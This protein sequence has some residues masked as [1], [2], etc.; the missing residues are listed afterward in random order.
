M[1]SSWKREVCRNRKGDREYNAITVSQYGNCTGKI[2]S[3]K[4]DY[5][6]DRQS[7]CVMWDVRD[8]TKSNSIRLHYAEELEVVE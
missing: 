3:S 4:K 6:R 5:T 2:V 7:I 1:T 8:E